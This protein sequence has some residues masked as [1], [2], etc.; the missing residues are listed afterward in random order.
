MRGIL[1]LAAICCAALSLCVPVSADP[2]YIYAMHDPGGEVDMNA[3]GTKGWIVFTVGI[4]HNPNDYSGTDYS[5]YTNNGY[6]VIVRLNNGYDSDGTLPYQSEYQNFAQRCAN[7]VANS[8]GCHI[9]IIGNETNLPREW[10][11]NVGGDPNTGEAI[12]V[13]R[14]VDCYN[15]CYNAIK[16][17]P[18]HASDQIIPAAVGTYGPP[19]NASYPPNRGIEGFAD[20]FVN[21]LNAIGST[22]VNAIAIHAY[23][24]GADPALVFS[25]ALMGPPYQ[26]IHYHFRV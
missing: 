25:E 12:T 8:P 5:S 3:M 6:G 10:P 17:L 9:W 18:G 19:Y 21:M 23:T 14:Y 13:A 22:K 1:F 26:D 11:G 7:Y 15:R 2:N 20:Y 4:G 24:H 16:A